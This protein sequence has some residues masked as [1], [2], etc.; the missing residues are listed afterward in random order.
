[1]TQ[2]DD[3]I[4]DFCRRVAPRGMHTPEDVLNLSAAIRERVAYTPG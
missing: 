4:R 1:L 2:C 3:T